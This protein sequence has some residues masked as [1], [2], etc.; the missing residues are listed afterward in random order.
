[1]SEFYDQPVVVIAHTDLDGY[2]ASAVCKK[3]YPECKIYYSNYG[4]AVPNAAFIPGCRMIVTDYSLLEHE[5]QKCKHLNIDCIWIDHHKDNYTMLEQKGV[6]WPGLRDANFCGAAL[7]WKFLFPGKEMP[8]VVQHVNDYDLWRFKLP[9]TKEFSAGIQLFEQ[10]ASYRTCVIWNDLLSDNPDVAKKALDDVISFGAKTLNFTKE[11]DAIIC[12][13]MS[14]SATLP[15]GQKCLVAATKGGNSSFFDSVDQS[16]ID[17]LCMAQYATDIKKYRCSVYSPDN[18]KEV[19]PIAK[20]FGGGGHPGA[21]GF[22][23]NAYPFPMPPLTTPRP[24]VEVI[25]EFGKIIELRKDLVVR[26]SAARGDKI[27]I[28]SRVFCTKWASSNKSCFAINHPY[29]SEFLKI[30]PS[31]VELIRSDTREI[32]G[33]VVGYTLT[34]SGYYRCGLFLIDESSLQ[35]KPFTLDLFK[36]WLPK[37]DPNSLVDS[38][39]EEVL[40]WNDKVMWWYSKEIPVIVPIDLIGG[41]K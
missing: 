8:M 7:T 35:G 23:A 26:Q 17:A 19:L 30:L 4:R 1:M 9:G 24:M 28:G 11:R 14:Y 16:G 20:S 27:N 18:I 12:K 3:R 13:D 10:R 34:N 38:A 41:G 40:P 36:S 22:Q 2:T 33:S 37:L 39:Y 5:F 32:V 25:K 21:A 29:M 6:C 15:T 31:S